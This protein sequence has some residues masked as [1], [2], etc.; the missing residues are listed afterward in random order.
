MPDD[1]DPPSV[2]VISAHSGDFVWRAGGA[3][4]L[5]ARR[6]SAVHVLC[7]SFGERGESPGLW[8]QPGM[9]VE[10]VKAARR[11]EA[12]AAAGILGAS[13]GFLDLG[14]YPLRVGEAAVE[15]IVAVMRERR[16][17]VLLTH[18]ARDPYNRDHDQ[19]HETTLLA[20]MVAQAHG[21][22]PGT[23]PLGAAQVFQFEPHQPE[24]CGFVPD[25]LLDVTPVFDLK[26]KAMGCMTAQEHLV[27]Y[28]TDLGVRRGVQAVRNGAPGTVTHAEAYRRT[29]PAVGDE[30]R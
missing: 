5:S 27:R 24:V 19:A 7:L 6:G 12:T 3:I 15:R 29:F 9:T 17:G 4:A 22:D 28:Y 2:L 1:R 13:I 25:L 20:R 14:D 23:P 8:K 30:L 11:D 10:R 16:P 18:V 26:V 21:H